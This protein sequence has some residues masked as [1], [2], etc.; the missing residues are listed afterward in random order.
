[1]FVAIVFVVFVIA[2]AAG[3]AVAVA[4]AAA[5]GFCHFVRCLLPFL[6]SMVQT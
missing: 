4:S 6:L 1:M 2:V 3:I 5:P